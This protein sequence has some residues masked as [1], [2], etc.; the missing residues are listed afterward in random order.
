METAHNMRLHRPP[1][2]QEESPSYRAAPHNL[3]AEQALLG[4]ILVNNEACDR[5]SGFLLPEHFYEGIHQRI[6]EAAADL[7]RAG[8][9]ADPVTLKSYFEQDTTLNEIGGPAYLARLAAAAT[10]IINTEEYG[11][12]VYELATRR[13]LISIGG[14]IVNESFEPI[15]GVGGA[16]TGGRGGSRSSS[17]A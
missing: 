1:E 13:R 10:T 12:L 4:A 16:A 11:R 17:A 7:I 14:D 9:R 5:V 8:R 3:D 15:P 6:Y 2:R